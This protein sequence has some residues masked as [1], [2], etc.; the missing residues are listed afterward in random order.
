VCKIPTLLVI[1]CSHRNQSRRWKDQ[2]YLSPIVLAELS[3][4]MCVNISQSKLLLIT[5]RKA[6]IQSNSATKAHLHDHKAI[7]LSTYGII[8]LGT[9]HQGVEGVN[10]ALIIL[11]IQSIYS[12]TKTSILKHLQRDSE[13]LQS[14][15]STY[16]S[17][18]GNFDTKFFYEAYPTQII[19]GARSI[20]S[21]EFFL[22]ARV[23]C[24]LLL[25]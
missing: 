14:Q 20:V 12:Q 24:L 25:F 1:N 22:Y 7:H 8:F 21:L 15:L 23:Q 10:L 16:A 13:F 3:S 18:S 11:G 5:R 9:P 6:L 2:L 4:N 17:I 19:G